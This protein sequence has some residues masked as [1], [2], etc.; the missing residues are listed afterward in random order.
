ME[1]V[2]DVIIIGAGVAGMNA[3]LYTIRSGKNATL[4]EGEAVGGQ[5]ANSPKVENFPTIP[6][7]SGAELADRLF[8][9]ISA[10]GVEKARRRAFRGENRLRR[11]SCQSRYC[12]NRRKT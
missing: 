5:I 11:V 4:F 8:D 9:Q 10:K 2:K 12:G 6:E 1:N 3:A 7:I